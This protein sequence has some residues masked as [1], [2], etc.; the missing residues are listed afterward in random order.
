MKTF[1]LI[2][3][4]SCLGLGA[5]VNATTLKGGVVLQADDVYRFTRVG[6][7][8]FFGINV[9]YAG[10]NSV[11]LATNQDLFRSTDKGITWQ[12]I[13]KPLDYKNITSVLPFGDTI[14]VGTSN[15]SIYGTNDHGLQWSLYSR[16]QGQ[17]YT[18]LHKEGEVVEGEAQARA[19]FIAHGPGYTSWITDSTFNVELA[20]GATMHSSGAVY[21]DA[22]SITTNGSAVYIGAKRDGIYVYD[23]TNSTLSSIGM[24]FLQGEYV[25]A[26]TTQDGFLYA[27]LRLGRGGVYRKPL[28]GTAWEPVLNDRIS[29]IVEITCLV[30]GSRGIY[31]GSREH[32]VSF[33]GRNS[34]LMRSISEV[35]HLSVIQSIGETDSLLIVA[36]RLRGVL[37]LSKSGNDLAMLSEDIPQ[38]PEYIVG[39]VG[40]SI[41]VGFSDGKL[42]RSDN[43]GKTWDSLPS[44]FSPASL[45][46]IVGFRKELFVTT[47]EGAWRSADTGRSWKPLHAGLTNEN[48]QKLVMHDSVIIVITSARSF[49]LR[50]DGALE[51]FDPHIAEQE[52]KPLLTGGVVYKGRL[53]ATGYPGLFVSNDYGRTWES[54]TVQKAMVLR[55]IAIV[56]N[57]MY[58]ATDMGNILSCPLP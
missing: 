53:Y 21:A 47:L 6:I 12:S 35:I 45:N 51:D 14:Y 48:I 29:G 22:S 25:N 26:L 15:G 1:R 2:I 37:R 39:N 46:T 4:A 3:L 18:A 58:V 52:H 36:C 16:P 24:D 49:L 8:T 34:R 10:E 30:A 13:A 42:I 31:A 32:G 7:N 5:L 17:P 27:G 23:V 50:P 41:L 20:A 19:A 11:L 54:H 55:T 28:V 57:M 56:D 33:I 9:I 44:P 40:N 38:S 43:V